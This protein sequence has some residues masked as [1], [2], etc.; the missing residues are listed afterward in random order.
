MTKVRYRS[1]FSPWPTKYVVKCFYCAETFTASQHEWH[2][3]KQINVTVWTE[4]QKSDTF[5][6]RRPWVA[7]VTRYAVITPIF[8]PDLIIESVFRLKNWKW[9]A[10]HSDRDMRTTTRAVRHRMAIGHYLKL[11]SFCLKP[12]ILVTKDQNSDQPWL[13][14]AFGY[15]LHQ[16]L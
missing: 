4:N 8:L 6:E 10:Q 16:F 13:L 2:A 7:L 11:G 12:F 3:S 9:L 15:Y 5:T 14:F 1:N